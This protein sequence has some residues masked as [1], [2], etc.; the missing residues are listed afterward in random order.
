MTNDS[1]P[2]TISKSKK[3]DELDARIMSLM[4]LQCTN[5]DI[6]KRL[7]VPL[8]TVQRRTRQLIAGGL[9]SVKV[10]L[11]HYDMGVKKGMLHIYLNNGDHEE[12]ARKISTL[13]TVNSVDVHIGNSDLVANTLYKDNGQLLQTISNI[14]HLEGVDR[15]V[16]SEEVY[17]IQNEKNI[18]LNLL[19][20]KI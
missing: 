2:L 1:T 8:S 11:N 5:K 20:L 4:L 13:D 12:L 19:G 6:S 10:E 9:I 14:K 7:G 18:G 16:W 15:V 3:I 17:S